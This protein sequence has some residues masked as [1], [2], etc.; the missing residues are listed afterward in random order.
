MDTVDA[1][2]EWRRLAEHYQQLTDSELIDLA[3]NRA[4]LTAVA[5][6][7]LSDEVSVRRL[8]IEPVEAKEAPPALVPEPPD[9][10]YAEERS[11]VTLCTAW[12]VRDA[13]QITTLLGRAG[14]PFYMGEERATAVYRVTSNFA[15]GVGVCIM[16]VGLPLAR[17]LLLD[18][19]PKDVPASEKNDELPDIFIRCPKCKSEEVVF[20]H[21]QDEDPATHQKI[22]Q[23]Y[24][25]KCDS[26]GYEWEDDGV[27]GE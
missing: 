20:E 11:L 2:G 25:W 23:K 16:N 22:V 4:E 21:M 19:F 18:Y 5:Q 17:N 13:L 14:I 15:E 6:Q 26:C 1:A 12:S 10:P 3:R 7:C 9:S 24:E 27:A 8:K